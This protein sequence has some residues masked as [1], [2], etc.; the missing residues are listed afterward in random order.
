MKKAFIIQTLFLFGFFYS[1]AQCR[2]VDGPDNSLSS[3]QGRGIT[4]WGDHKNY[5]LVTSYLNSCARFVGQRMESLTK[6][7]DVHQYAKLYADVS[8]KIADYGVEYAHWQN[9]LSNSLPND[10]GCGYKDWNAHLNYVKTSG[11]GNAADLVKKRMDFLSTAI[12]REN[13]ASLYADVS[14]II[15]KHA[16]GRSSCGWID[17]QDGSLSS[18]GGRGVTRWEDHL[19]Y[20]RN[21][22]DLASCANFVGDRLTT[23]TSCL[24]KNDYAKVYA[25]VSVKIAEYGDAYANWKN[26]LSNALPNDGGCGYKD[27]NAHLDYVKI[28]GVGNAAALVKNRMSVLSGILTLDNYAKLYADVSVI[29]A[30]YGTGKR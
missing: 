28:N 13:Y 25:D 6:C 2:W 11:Y 29:I 1:S 17:G 27:W 12:S 18:D 26:S 21:T 3:D 8:V 23:L 5:G 30:K 19:L 14:V 22:H 24:D 9:S 16:L 7:M 10:G 15:A 4:Q 20:A